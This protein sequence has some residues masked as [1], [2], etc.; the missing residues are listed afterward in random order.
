MHVV[1]RMTA[2]Y[3]RCIITRSSPELKYAAFFGA[4]TEYY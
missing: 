2:K 3:N 1:A 4:C